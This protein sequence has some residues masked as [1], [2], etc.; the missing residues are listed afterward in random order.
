[1]GSFCNGGKADRSDAETRMTDAE[2]TLFDHEGHEG[3]KVTKKAVGWV[4]FV[5]SRGGGTEWDF[6]GHFGTRGGFVLY[7]G[8]C[9]PQRRRDAENGCGEDVV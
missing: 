7:W 6:V 8:K 5:L 4:R 2:K 1:M 9:R 3:T